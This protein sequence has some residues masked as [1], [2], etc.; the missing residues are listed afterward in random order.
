RRSFLLFFV[1]FVESVSN[2]DTKSTDNHEDPF[3]SF[4]CISWN[5]CLTLTQKAQ[6]TTKILSTLFRAFSGIRV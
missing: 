6:I 1:H 2:P 3:Y 5:P 4:S